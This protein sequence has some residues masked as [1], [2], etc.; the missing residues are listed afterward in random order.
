M[1]VTEEQQETEASEVT[2]DAEAEE[3]PETPEAVEDT[4]AAGKPKPVEP[5]ERP[6]VYWGLGRR[7]SAVARVRVMRG[8]GNIVVNGR[9]AEQYFTD[10][11]QI[12]AVRGPLKH[13]KLTGRYDVLVTATGGGIGG[14]SGAVVLG[15]ARAFVKA[16]PD[17]EEKLRSLG[18]LTRDPRMKERKKFGKRGARA[19]FQFSKR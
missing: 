1:G 5:K 10:E 16:E 7:K 6:T 3:A 9:D 15:M 18:L 8:T 14:Q 4:Q 11:R 2:T 19:S 17:C 13:L 12:Q